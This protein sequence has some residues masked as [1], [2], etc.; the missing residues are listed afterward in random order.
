[1]SHSK[2]IEEREE[3]TAA[4]RG[5]TDPARPRDLLLVISHLYFFHKKVSR[6][7]YSSFCGRKG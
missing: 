7:N 5:G 4:M 2:D 6:I 1:L 3:F